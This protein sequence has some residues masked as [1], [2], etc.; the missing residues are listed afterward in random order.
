MANFVPRPGSLWQATDPPWA[1]TT[2]RAVASPSPLAAEAAPIPFKCTA[3][4]WMGGYVRVF[5]HPYHAVTA[6][7]GTFE[8][9]DAPAGQY[10]VVYW[11]EKVGFKGGK[12]GRLGEPVAVAAGPG[13]AAAELKP[14][15]FDVTK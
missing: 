4:P 5:D 8:I 3:H 14:T 2:R 7:G 13:G 1:S 11:H 15:P 12:D 6:A 9:K 10:R